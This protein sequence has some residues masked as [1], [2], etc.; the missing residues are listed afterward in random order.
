MYLW[1]NTSIEAAMTSEADRR[2]TT[3]RLRHVKKKD[4]SFFLWSIHPHKK[5]P[6]ENSPDGLSPLQIKLPSDFLFTF[7]RHLVMADLASAA[8]TS[9]RTA[10]F[11]RLVQVLVRGSPHPIGVV[12]YV[13]GPTRLRGLK[14]RGSH[15]PQRRWLHSS[16][17]CFRSDF[18]FFAFFVIDVDPFLIPLFPPFFQLNFLFAGQNNFFLM[19]FSSSFEKSTRTEKR[20]FR[21]REEKL[22]ECKRTFLK[23]KTK[24]ALIITTF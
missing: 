24:I 19:R 3:E 12:H 1:L 9:P 20:F 21:R 22:F 16:P 10:Y 4:S 17:P 18:L 13:R 8:F 14:L 6:G 5:R 11:N 15:F 23:A 2:Q 7:E